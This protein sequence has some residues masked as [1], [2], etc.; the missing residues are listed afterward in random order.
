M[1]ERT[2]YLDHLR[3]V[4]TAFVLLMHTGMTYGGSGSWFYTEIFAIQSRSS[5]LLTICI[6]ISNAYLMS[7]F[8]LLA[9]Y[10]APASYQRKG[11]ARFLQDRFTR[12]GIPLLLFVLILG[13]LT[14]GL[15]AHSQGLPFL[16]TVTRLLRNR[17]FINGPMWFAEALL[18]FSLGYCC[19]YGLRGWPSATPNT[20]P[21]PA[22]YVWLL[23]TLT[24]GIGALV[25]RQFIPIDRRVIGLWL[26]NFVPYI[27][28]F[29]L[30]AKANR[31]GWL[32]RFEW[33]QARLSITFTALALPALPAALTLFYAQGGTTSTVRGL[34]WMNVFYSLWEPC[35]AAGLIAAF[36]LVFRRFVNNSSLIWAWLDRRAYAVYFIHP[37]IL[38]ALC[39]SLRHWHAHA[40]TKFILVGTLGCITTWLVADFI[41]RLP[42]L[43]KIL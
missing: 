13:P 31:A 15:V 37:P 12:L 32:S 8:F 14:V 16:P 3:S 11:W 40:L 19:W 39:L 20:K 5:V 35:V 24:V 25:L 7:F 38:V 28:F 33:R 26:G 9:G 17:T 18:L 21:V 22:S 30:G 34:S 29:C 10:F 41:I 27:F 36:L 1:A 6:V 2:P 23:S 42:G 43:R 4:M